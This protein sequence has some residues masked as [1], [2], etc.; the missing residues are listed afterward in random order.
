MKLYALMKEHDNDLS[1]L[2]VSTYVYTCYYRELTVA[3][4]TL[5]NGKP[6]KEAK[7]E[8]AY[9]SSFIEVCKGNATHVRGLTYAHAVVWY[10]LPH[11]KL[12]SPILTFGKAEEA[13]RTYGGWSR[14][15][16][17]TQHF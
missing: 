9:S 5:E 8:Q 11:Q 2:I 6:F 7:G 12:L 1:R 14:P 15:T 10:V 4:Q 16:I 13:V 17:N 3:T